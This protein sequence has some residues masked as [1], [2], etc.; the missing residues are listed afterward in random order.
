MFQVLTSLAARSAL[1]KH[2]PLLAHYP[3]FQFSLSVWNVL[4]ITREI[5]EHIRKHQGKH[6]GSRILQYYTVAP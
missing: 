2:A 6:T 1:L 3:H 5:Q 4:T